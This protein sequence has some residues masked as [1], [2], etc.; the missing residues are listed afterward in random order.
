MPLS[1]K[2][3]WLR[4]DGQVAIQRHTAGGKQGLHLGQ[5]VL[6]F[7]VIPAEIYC[8]P[9]RFFLLQ[10][11]FFFFAFI[12]SATQLYSSFV[13]SLIYSLL[14]KKDNLQNAFS[15]TS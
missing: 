8:F 7:Q 9:L 14:K 4:E 13:Y 15:I 12:S 6:G 10:K 1:R 11:L 5:A 2:K 3:K